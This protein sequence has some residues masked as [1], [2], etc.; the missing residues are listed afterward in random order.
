MPRKRQSWGQKGWDRLY[1]ET[2]DSSEARNRLD[3]GNSRC[4]GS[5]AGVNLACSCDWTGDNGT[6]GG[7]GAKIVG[8][9]HRKG[10]DLTVRVT[11]RGVLGV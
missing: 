4:K 9:G 8:P 11:R 5:A 10:R 7:K 2:A 1:K 3:R 6:S